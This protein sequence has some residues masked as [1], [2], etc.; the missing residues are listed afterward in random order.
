[1]VIL[2]SF[3][4]RVNLSPEILGSEEGVPRFPARRRSGGAKNG[5][6]RTSARS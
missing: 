6:R 4:S 5:R 2:F 1:M 3:S